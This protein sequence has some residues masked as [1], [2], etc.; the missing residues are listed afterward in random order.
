MPW[1]RHLDLLMVFRQV[2][3]MQAQAATARPARVAKMVA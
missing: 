2:T 1:V 3:Q